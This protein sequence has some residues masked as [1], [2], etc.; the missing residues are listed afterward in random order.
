MAAVFGKYILPHYV[1]EIQPRCD[2]Y[3][4]FA[5]LVAV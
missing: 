2:M 3:L 4:Q 1:C 5:F